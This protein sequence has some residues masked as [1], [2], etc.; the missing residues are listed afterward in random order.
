MK[1]EAYEN[2]VKQQQ[3]GKRWTHT[4]GVVDTAIK[5]AKQYGADP[6][7]A[8]LAALFHDYAKAWSVDR[9]VAVIR[10][11]GLPNDLLD[12][13]KQLLHAPVG[14]HVVGE[15]FQI[16]DEVI[17]DA[18][19]YHT[20]GRE[21]MTVLDKV[22]CLADYMEPGRDF[23][24]VERIRKLAEHSLEE[25]LIAAFDSTI[26]YL[27]SKGSKVYP[28]TFIARNQLIDELKEGADD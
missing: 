2:A 25:A 13:G 22:I 16:K 20:T 4:L 5:L 23:P 28:L 14:A 17:L 8:D 12:Y 9:L 24:G 7:K 26:Q 15:Q 19:R 10:E 27:I 1:R 18:I 3:P 11:H 6:E 21:R